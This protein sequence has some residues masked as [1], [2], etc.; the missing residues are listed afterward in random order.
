MLTLT[1]AILWAGAVSAAL[2]SRDYPSDG[3]LTKCPG[4]KASNVK[5]STSGLTADLSLAGTAC[6]VYSDDLKDLT[7][8]VT[9]E[10]RNDLPL[11]LAC[12]K[13][14]TRHGQNLAF[15]SRFKMLEIA[16]TKFLHLSSLGQQLQEAHQGVRT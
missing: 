8:T 12:Y 16:C 3:P 14:L 2:I 9:Y 7:L 15:I 5:T 10:S 13:Q 11:R 6:N 4:Y 1:R